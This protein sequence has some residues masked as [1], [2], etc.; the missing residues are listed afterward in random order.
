MYASKHGPSISWRGLYGVSGGHEFRLRDPRYYA[1]MDFARL[2]YSF[3]DRHPRT[4][5]VVPPRDSML[6]A[7][8]SLY[9]RARIA[10]DHAGA[11]LSAIRLYEDTWPLRRDLANMDAPDQHILLCEV[12]LDE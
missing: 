2:S 1:P 8:A 4:W 5:T 9:E 3:A 10:G 6:R 11:P 7:V 12:L